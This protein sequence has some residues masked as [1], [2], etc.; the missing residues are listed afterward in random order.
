MSES[1]APPF[2]QD[3]V[4]KALRAWHDTKETPGT[5][6]NAFLSVRARRQAL[7]DDGETMSPRRAANEVLLGGIEKLAVKDELG[8]QILRERFA[9]NETIIKVAFNHEIGED[10]V[11]RQQRK[12]IELLTDILFQ[13]DQPLRQ[14]YI[15]QQESQ[16]EAPSYTQLFGVE[17]SLNTLRQVLQNENAPWL[18]SITGLGGLGKS[19][20]ADAA[21]R[22][23]I[24]AVQFEQIAWVRAEI[25]TM[26]G[27]SLSPELMFE[28]LCIELASKLRPEARL[29]SNT[30]RFIR[31]LLK[32]AP[33]LVV[34]DNLESEVDTVFLFNQLAD[35]GGPS[36]IVI[37][38]RTRP[39]A[40]ANVFSL[41]LTE[42]SSSDAL[43]LIRH[44]AEITGLPA[45]ANADDGM[46]S[47]IIEATGG[48]PH[49][50]KLI[51]SLTHSLSLSNI[52]SNFPL[53]RSQPIEKMFHDIY[54]KA[55]N[56]LSAPARTLLEAMP[57]VAM[58]GAQY[59][60]LQVVSELSEADLSA[61][62]EELVSRSLLEV[63]G[64]PFDR[65]YGIHRLTETFLQTEIIGWPEA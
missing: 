55:W 3:A 8:A 23:M 16:L 29:G 49:A 38:S 5:L 39:P 17:G 25:H 65:R 53:G 20:L 61:A 64:T 48:N 52:L 13:A 1:K 34:I 50:I 45:L 33:H 43:A 30:S 6:L 47:P 12:A 28:D 9:N 51:V 57:L 11:N 40:Q 44:H 36:K 24:Q 22:E 10:Q 31:Q 63:R 37:T 56:A 59:E 35:L 7:L 54:W 27:E 46:L 2:F 42:L 4:H 19:S 21:A 41:P 15:V 32:T 14:A 58:S 60:Q 62:I 26:S 18:I